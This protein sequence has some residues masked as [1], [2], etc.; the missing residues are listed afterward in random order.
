MPKANWYKIKGGIKRNRTVIPCRDQ[1]YVDHVEATKH[2]AA[3]P[4]DHE[5]DVRG[6]H[7]DDCLCT[8]LSSSKDKGKL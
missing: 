7:K 8:R 2:R 5:F 1:A 4:I 6:L 3:N